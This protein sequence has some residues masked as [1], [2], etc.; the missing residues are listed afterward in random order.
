MSSQAREADARVGDEHGPVMVA[1]RYR[2]H[3]DQPLPALNAPGGVC[4]FNATDERGSPKS[5][6]ALV[7]RRDVA[8]RTAVLNQFARFPRL[9]LVKPLRWGEFGSASRRG[10]VCQSVLISGGAVSLKKT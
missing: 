10:R 6:F 7:C 8:P 3:P 4:A 9:P 1:D 5:L 2:I